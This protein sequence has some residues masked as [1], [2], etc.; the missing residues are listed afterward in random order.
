MRPD[1]NIMHV[2]LVEFEAD[3][4]AILV[5][6]S[7]VAG[8]ALKALLFSADNAGTQRMLPASGSFVRF[9][10]THLL[11][12]IEMIGVVFISPSA[13]LEILMEGVTAPIPR[14]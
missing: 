11:F 14:L 6:T 7:E 2:D 1:H 13:I 5:K 8:V 3:T 12:S 4:G 10:W 9:V